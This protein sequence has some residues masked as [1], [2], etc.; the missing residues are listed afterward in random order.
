ML[1]LAFM[2]YNLETTNSQ[3]I[4]SVLFFDFFLAHCV[5]SNQH[6]MSGIYFHKKSEWQKMLICQVL[7]YFVF[8]FIPNISVFTHF[9]CSE[10]ERKMRYYQAAFKKYQISGKNFCTV[11]FLLQ[12]TKM[13][14]PFISC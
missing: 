9:F 12:T 1:I 10:K 2:L 14:K 5:S 6:E 11:F 3:I 7:L 4:L 13:N 8:F